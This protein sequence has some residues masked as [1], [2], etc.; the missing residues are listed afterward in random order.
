MLGTASLLS[1]PSILAG[2][3]YRDTGKAASNISPQDGTRASEL[4]GSSP[5]SAAS[6]PN[7]LDLGAKEAQR[8]Q[9]D[10][11][12]YGL[13]LGISG[14]GTGRSSRLRARREER[15]GVLVTV[16]TVSR[17][18]DGDWLHFSGQRNTNTTTENSASEVEMQRRWPRL[19]ALRNLSGDDTCCQS[20]ER[21]DQARSE[22]IAAMSAQ[23]LPRSQKDENCAKPETRP[24]S[25]STKTN[26][27]SRSKGS[28]SSREEVE[29]LDYNR[30]PRRTPYSRSTSD[31]S[32]TD[33][34]WSPHTP[35]SPYP[36]TPTT[37]YSETPFLTYPSASATSVGRQRA[38]S[39][40]FAGAAAPSASWATPPQSPSFEFDRWTAS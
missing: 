37:T 16:G 34:P 24:R 28:P 9:S 19:S 33:L 17:T 21:R 25:S 30:V 7:Y 36:H 4:A 3:V 35:S 27:T 13:G 31:S 8:T 32:M 29:T 2:S 22:R 26:G 12:G 18:D 10:T 11:L 40:S 20:G 39:P 14:S 15:N 1:V 6:P 23:A 5:S 38:L